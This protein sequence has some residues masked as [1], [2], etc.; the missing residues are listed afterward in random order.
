MNPGKDFERFLQQWNAICIT[1]THIK[2]ETV[3]ISKPQNSWKKITII[4]YKEEKARLI[5]GCI[6]KTISSNAIECNACI[7]MKCVIIQKVDYPASLN[8]DSFDPCRDWTMTVSS[9]T[10]KRNSSHLSSVHNKR[11]IVSRK[12]TFL[13][14]PF[15]IDSDHF[16][17]VIVTLELNTKWVFSIQ[18]H[19]GCLNFQLIIPD[20]FWMHPFS[21]VQRI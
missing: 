21:I 8:V 2:Y 9:K 1:K 20:K 14:I 15:K 19:R 7:F 12:Y 4:A 16:R 11:H 6:H 10:W 17:S 3:W 5:L 18:L 13:T